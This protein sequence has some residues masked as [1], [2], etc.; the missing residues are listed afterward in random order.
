MM[1]DLRGKADA[2]V[3]EL[4]EGINPLYRHRFHAMPPAGWVNDPNGF[5]C[6]N[7]QYHLFCQFNPYQP[8]WGPMHWGHWVSRDLTVWERMPVALAPDMPYDAGGCFSGHAVLKDGGLALLYTGVSAKGGDQCQQQCAA[9]SRDGISFDKLPENP[10]IP[11]SSLPSGMS[12]RDFRDPKI[13]AID[14][15]YRA[16]VASRDARG[17][18]LLCWR[19]HDLKSWQRDGELIAGVGDMLECPDYFCLDGCRVL[20]VCVMGMPEGSFGAPGCQ[21]AVWMGASAVSGEFSANQAAALDYGPDFYA[22]QTCM[23]PD[24]RRIMIA[25]MSS[26]NNDL[27]TR[28]LNHGWNGSMT[29]PRELSFLGGRLIQRPAREIFARIGP[30]AA[31][32]GRGSIVCACPVSAMI[33]ASIGLHGEDVIDMDVFR[34]GD[35]RLRIRYSATDG[36]LTADRSLCGYPILKDAVTENVAC[37]TTVSLF[38][39]RLELQIFLDV[40]SVEIFAS[41][42]EKTLTLLAFPMGAANTFAIA[43]L[44]G[45]ADLRVSIGAI[46]A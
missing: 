45:Q 13:L 29:L 17:G 41:G 18:R 6:Y 20:T 35:E 11:A 33:D 5:I 3:S 22:P 31:F 15:G 30:L 9:V 44:S 14:G 27:P 10:V 40:C 12:A 46:T 19:S 23:A 25:W 38:A 7:G 37:A 1:T 24:G 2:A 21:P 26:W 42:G 16:I 4:A 39:G 8:V 34:S 36:L 32:R 43:S 28:R